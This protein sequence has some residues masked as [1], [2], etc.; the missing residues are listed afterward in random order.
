MVTSVRSIAKADRAMR[1]AGRSSGSPPSS[2][3][4]KGPAGTGAIASSAI[5]AVQAESPPATTIGSKYMVPFV[6]ILPRTR[7]EEATWRYGQHGADARD[8]QP[9]LCATA[10]TGS[11][12]R[13]AGVPGGGAAERRRAGGAGVRLRRRAA[14]GQAAAGPDRRPGGPAQDRPDRAVRP[15]RDR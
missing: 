12:T 15:A 13:A 8:P 3:R 11:S 4:T 10:L 7:T 2:P 9:G 14:R 6:T 5:T 1:L